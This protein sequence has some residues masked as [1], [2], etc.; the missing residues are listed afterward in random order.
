MISTK[1]VPVTVCELD[2]SK[3]KPPRPDLT[4]TV[5]PQKEK[6]IINLHLL[7]MLSS[8]VE[9][10][11]FYLLTYTHVRICR[12]YLF[13]GAKTDKTVILIYFNKTST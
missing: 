10:K 8:L 6:H 3:I 7:F 2:I 11:R 4:R 5:A 12:F 13:F 9:A 1:T